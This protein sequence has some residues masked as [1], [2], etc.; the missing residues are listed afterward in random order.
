MKWIKALFQ[1][2]DREEEYAGSVQPEANQTQTSTA[3]SAR[4]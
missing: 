2:V 3:T 1:L 4:V